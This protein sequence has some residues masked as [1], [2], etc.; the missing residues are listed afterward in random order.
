MLDTN[1]KQSS[2]GAGPLHIDR[3]AGRALLAG[4]ELPLT[5][6]EFQVLL[7]LAERVNRV[8]SRSDFLERVWMVQND[9][10]TNLLAVYIRRLR[11]KLGA[12]AGMIMTIR[13]I[14]YR[15]RPADA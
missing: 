5:D 4:D 8:V 3:E 14:G 13:G 7:C 15:L 9:D 6:R 10:G 1:A 11:R 12:H 2:L